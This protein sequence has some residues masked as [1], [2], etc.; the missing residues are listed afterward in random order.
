MAMKRILGG[1]SAPLIKT[2]TLGKDIVLLHSLYGN[3]PPDT[4]VNDVHLH[5]ALI[6]PC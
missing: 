5:V 2:L 6:I 1:L 3:R 4:K